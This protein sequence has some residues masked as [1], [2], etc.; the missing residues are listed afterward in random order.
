MSDFDQL[1][2]K[3]NELKNIKKKLCIELDSIQKE[4]N[5]CTQELY[6]KCVESGGHYFQREY[7]YQLYGE[8]ILTCT[9]CGYIK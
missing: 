8:V 5:L 7:D 3:K 1:L 4:L 6:G 2:E 9:H